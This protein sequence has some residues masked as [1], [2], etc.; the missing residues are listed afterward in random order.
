MSSPM[1]MRVIAAFLSMI[2]LLA[3]PGCLTQGIDRDLCEAKGGKWSFRDRRCTYPSPT[4]TWEVLKPNQTQDAAWGEDSGDAAEPV[5]DPDPEPE[6]A[7]EVADLPLDQC[8]ARDFISHKGAGESELEK[9]KARE[10]CSYTVTLRNSHPEKPIW[11]FGYL[12]MSSPDGERFEWYIGNQ[13][14][15]DE[16]K[17]W[18]FE[19]RTWIADN[20]VYHYQLI[21]LAGFFATLG[22]EWVYGET[23]LYDQLSKEIFDPCE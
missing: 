4:T 13:L 1:K 11:V 14:A 23:G 8:I 17:D 16:S 18:N 21:R 22:C 3:T 6:T 12:N 10:K 5:P 20:E 2:I 15:P 7:P 19:K 9:T